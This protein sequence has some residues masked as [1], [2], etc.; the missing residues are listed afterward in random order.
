MKYTFVLLLIPLLCFFQCGCCEKKE[1]VVEKPAK[2][3]LTV[4]V[5]EKISYEIFVPP[6][7]DPKKKYP[8]IFFLS[9]SGNPNIYTP[10]ILNACRSENFI[11]AG[12]YNFRNEISHNEFLPAIKKSLQH[13]LDNYPVHQ[14]LLYLAGFSGGGQGAYVISHFE[15]DRFQGLIVNN[16]L[17]HPNIRDS[18][19]LRYLGINKVAILVGNNDTLVTPVALRNDS[20]L[21]QRSGI[22][23][24]MLNFDGGHQV[25]PEDIYL[26]AVKWLFQ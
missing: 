19:A 1:V 25:A 22:M 6:D 18:E 17:I 7:L 9:P 2:Q 23:V 20:A 4:Q 15:K 8:L 13:I 21:L 10:V 26:Q 3:T 12:S 14:K 11:F 16:G 24:Q 5:D